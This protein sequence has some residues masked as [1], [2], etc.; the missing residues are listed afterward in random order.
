MVRGSPAHNDG[1][2]SNPPS[3][4]ASAPVDQQ[5]LSELKCI[6]SLLEKR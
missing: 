1:T 4:I 2:G 6:R 3:S 5:I